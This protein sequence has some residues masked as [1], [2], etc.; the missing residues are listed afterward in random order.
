MKI[1]NP[2]FSKEHLDLQPPK[3]TFGQVENR[4]DVFIRL[5]PK[6][7]ETEDGDSGWECDLCEFSTTDPDKEAIQANP[8]HYYELAGEDEISAAEFMEM[9]LND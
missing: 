2:Q 3:V 6:P 5:N 7:Y 4:T 9:L 1:L 8:E